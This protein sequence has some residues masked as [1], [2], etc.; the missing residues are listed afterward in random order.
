[1][2]VP[3]YI[4]GW[5]VLTVFSIVLQT[6][7]FKRVINWVEAVVTT[8]VCALWPATIPLSII[9]GIG[10]TASNLIGRSFAKKDN[11]GF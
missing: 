9:V 2:S 4:L 10:L 11:E 8:C 5:A 7:V 3:V 1:M 6:I